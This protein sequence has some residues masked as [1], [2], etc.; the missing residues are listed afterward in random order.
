MIIAQMNSIATADDWI[1][2][3]LW[4]YFYNRSDKLYDLKASCISDMSQL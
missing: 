3:I 2:K 1:Y 4:N